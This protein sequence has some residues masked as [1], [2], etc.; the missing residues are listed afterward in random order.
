MN[1]HDR[2]RVHNT[3]FVSNLKISQNVNQIIIVSLIVAIVVKIILK[4]I[5]SKLKKRK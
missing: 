4:I 1:I 5:V 2:S 3:D